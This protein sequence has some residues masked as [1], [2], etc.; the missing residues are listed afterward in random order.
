M[1][2]EKEKKK[3]ENK[4]KSLFGIRP[5]HHIMISRRIMGIWLEYA[6]IDRYDEEPI[7]LFRKTRDHYSRLWGPKNVR[8]RLCWD[9]EMYNG[10]GERLK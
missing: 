8:L 3:E 7:D 9:S 5:Y 4:E 6:M 10:K 2:K 1:K